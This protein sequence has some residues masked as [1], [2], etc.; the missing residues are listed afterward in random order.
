[1]STPFTIRPA[2]EAD[3]ST[4][5]RLIR[6]AR[7]APMGLS[8]PNFLVAEADGE[9]VGIGQ[10]KSHADGSRELASIAVVP[11]RQGQGIGSAI[12]KALLGREAG[13]TLHLTCRSELE[14]YYERFE[15]QRLERAEYPPHFGRMVPVVNLVMRF[16]G[17]RI[18]VMRRSGTG[19]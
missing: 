4:I 2:T 5:R 6:E 11:D 9:T 1:M 3:Q 16:F 10:V 19:R 13:V 14:G 8:W 17:M 7:L 15:F 18:I 12:I